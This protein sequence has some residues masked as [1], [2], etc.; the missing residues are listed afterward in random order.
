M[1]ETEIDGMNLEQ[2]IAVSATIHSL[3]DDASNPL[4]LTAV[5]T[6]YDVC[7]HPGAEV[8]DPNI[9]KILTEKNLIQ[10]GEKKVAAEVA[11]IVRATILNDQNS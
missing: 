6:F 11:T 9:I 2:I 3:Q 7:R 10:A 4:N 1:Q 5:N 8:E